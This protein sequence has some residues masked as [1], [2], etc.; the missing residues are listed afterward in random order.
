MNG[1]APK[2]ATDTQM[3]DVAADVPLVIRATV[4]DIRVRGWQRQQVSIAIDRSASASDLPLVVQHVEGK[5]VIS[6]EQGKGRKDQAVRANLTVVVPTQQ[7]LEAVELFEGRLTL[8][9]LRGGVSARVERGSVEAR[10]MGGSVRLET[11]L[12]SIRLEHEATTAPGPIRLRTFNGDVSLRFSRLPPH[13]RLLALT[14]N[15]TIESAVPLTRRAGLGP[16][17]AETTLG[18]GEPVVSI[19]VVTGRIEIETGS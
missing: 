12:G 14:M 6:L 9:G 2:G 10:N 4:G 7:E 18:R 17:F 1:T 19:D 11:T 5:L 3:V 8:D 13:L 16:Q 15:G